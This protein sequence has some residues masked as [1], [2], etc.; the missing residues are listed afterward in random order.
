MTNS[1]KQDTQLK[2]FEFFIND[3]KDEVKDRF[4]SFLGGDN[5][6]HDTIPFCIYETAVTDLDD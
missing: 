4:I 2:K 1:T 5:G 3:L 6:N